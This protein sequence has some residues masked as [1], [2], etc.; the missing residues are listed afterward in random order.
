[1]SNSS[2]F[3]K[4]SATPSV[5]NSNSIDRWNKRTVQLNWHDRCEFYERGND[6]AVSEYDSYELVADVL[7]HFNYPLSG[8]KW[9]K[10]WANKSV[11]IIVID[12]EVHATIIESEA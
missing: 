10:Y 1:M 6:M 2:A 3:K 11:E 9:S 4:D 12:D 8:S 5:R 7:D